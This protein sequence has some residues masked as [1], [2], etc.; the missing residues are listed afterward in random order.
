MCSY[1]PY[2]FHEYPIP[3]ESLH[4]YQQ[5]GPQYIGTGPITSNHPE[6]ATAVSYKDVRCERNDNL[7][8]VNIEN[9]DRRN[10]ELKNSQAAWDSTILPFQQ[11]NFYNPPELSQQNNFNFYKQNSAQSTTVENLCSFKQLNEQQSSVC[12]YSTYNT[13]PGIQLNSYIPTHKQRCDYDFTNQYCNQN[14]VNQDFAAREPIIMQYTKQN[15]YELMNKDMIQNNPSSNYSEIIQKDVIHS[16]GPRLTHFPIQLHDMNQKRIQNIEDITPTDDL[17][18]ISNAEIETI[19]S[20]I[21]EQS[22]LLF[23][24]LNDDN[25]KY[26][27]EQ[28]DITTIKTGSNEIILNEGTKSISTDEKKVN[29][30]ESIER[31]KKKSESQLLKNYDIMKYRNA[32]L[33]ARKTR[34]KARKELQKMFLSNQAHNELI[35]SL[36]KIKKRKESKGASSKINC[37]NNVHKTIQEK[38][39]GKIDK[40]SVDRFDSVAESNGTSTKQ[41]PSEIN[42]TNDDNIES[43]TGRNAGVE[44]DVHSKKTENDESETKQSENTSS[45]VS[46]LQSTDTDPES[47]IISNSFDADSFSY[48]ASKLKRK[49]ALKKKPVRSNDQTST[50]SD[51]AIKES[52]I[53]D[54]SEKLVMNDDVKELKNPCK[55]EVQIKLVKLNLPQQIKKTKTRKKKCKQKQNKLI[56]SN[57]NDSKKDC[58][59]TQVDNQSHIF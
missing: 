27:Q 50:G 37:V 57:Q 47:K 6:C 11:K 56:N 13:P 8:D 49:E 52:K 17:N 18:Y 41:S 12:Q 55:H 35:K 21:L 16:E 32:L 24:F 19:A 3:V 46:Q 14:I 48:D 44:G 26:E 29:L 42:R 33:K 40:K 58:E 39:F 54:E 43:D 5:V 23:P 9:Q 31:T 59:K 4:S 7:E 20:K 51:L 1:Q 28:H 34:M 30:D 38:K 2:Q 25:I 45:D 10:Y 22:K 36:R 53:S 15:Q